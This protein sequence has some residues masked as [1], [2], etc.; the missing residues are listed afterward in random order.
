VVLILIFVAS[1][2]LIAVWPAKKKKSV[3]KLRPFKMKSLLTTKTVSANAVF[4][5]GLS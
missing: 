2:L 3:E 4:N 1:Q 5:A